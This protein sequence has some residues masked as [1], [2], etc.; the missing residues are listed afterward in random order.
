MAPA[1]S[2]YLIPPPKHNQHQHPPMPPMPTSQPIPKPTVPKPTTTTTPTPN[3]PT[4]NTIIGKSS[5][6]HIPRMESLRINESDHPSS[7]KERHGQA[8]YQ[9]PDNPYEMRSTPTNHKCHSQSTH[10]SQYWP[11]NSITIISTLANCPSRTITNS[12]FIF[13]PT[14]DATNHNIN[15]LRSYNFDLNEALSNKQYSFSRKQDPNFVP[16]LIWNH[17][18]SFTHCGPASKVIYLRVSSF[19]SPL[20]HT[21]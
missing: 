3:T 5:H 18:Y 19:L 10:H 21:L 13:L 6:F 1:A 16:P 15:I 9:Q 7:N 8:L 4:K 14:T 20:F 2:P 17:C 12:N 11:N